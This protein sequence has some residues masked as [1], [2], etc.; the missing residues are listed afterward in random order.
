MRGAAWVLAAMALVLGDLPARGAE[1][2]ALFVVQYVDVAPSAQAA[3]EASLRQARARGRKEDGNLRFEA[4]AEAGRPSR[5]AMVSLWRDQK[6]FEAYA[7]SAGALQLRAAL[8][9]VRIT[10]IDERQL[11]LLAGDLLGAAPRRAA[12]GARALYVVTHMDS[13]PTFKDEAAAALKQLAAASGKDAGLVR[14]QVL[15]QTNRAN[16]FELLEVWKDRA[17]FD[18]HVTAPHTKQFRDAVQQGAGSPYDERLY[19]S[20]E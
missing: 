20:L 4:Y 2:P 18:A 6:A 7:A 16:H 15:V 11:S 12:A 9:P 17:S 13:L 5:F 19:K 14:Y 3:A 8:D 1:E 10:A